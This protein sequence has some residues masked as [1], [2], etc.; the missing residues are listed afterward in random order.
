MCC[1]SLLAANTSGIIIN[2]CGWIK[3]GGYQ[4]LVHTAGSF[5]VDAIVVLDQERLYNE[6]VRDMPEFVKVAHLP[7]S[8]GVVV[9]S[10]KR[11]MQIREKKI[12]EYFYGVDNCLFPHTFQ[13][14]FSDIKLFKI[15]GMTEFLGN[16]LL[17]EYDTC[18]SSL[19]F[20]ICRIS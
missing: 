16:M 15:G 10:S 2:T 1:V 9:R 4:S 11:R 5:E 19:V 20:D 6:L 8:G 18:R 13:V 14:A 12:H 17:F 3:G 7:K